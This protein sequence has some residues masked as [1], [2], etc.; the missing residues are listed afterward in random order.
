MVWEKEW[1]KVRGWGEIQTIKDY[2]FSQINY[3]SNTITMVKEYKTIK[4]N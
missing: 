1:E 2:N 4:A 3:L